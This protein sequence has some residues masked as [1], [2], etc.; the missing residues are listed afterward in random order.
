M[1]VAQVKAFQEEILAYALKKN[2]DFVKKLRESKKLDEEI[3]KS[4]NEILKMYLEEIKI[5]EEKTKKISSEEDDFEHIAG[6]KDK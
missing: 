2:P 3:E 4:I 5:I 1:S 6:A